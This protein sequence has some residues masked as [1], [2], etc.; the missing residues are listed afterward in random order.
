LWGEAT[1]AGKLG[2]IV[3]YV[4]GNAGTITIEKIRDATLGFLLAE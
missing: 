2:L 3:E 1:R 4:E